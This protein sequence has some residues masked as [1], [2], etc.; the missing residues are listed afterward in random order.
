MNALFSVDA[1]ERSENI[2]AIEVERSTLVSARVIEFEG[3]QRLDFEEV[4]DNIEAQLRADEA[5]RLAREFGDGLLAKL[6]AGEALDDEWST[7][8]RVQRA[9]PT[10]PPAAMQAVFGAPAA[11]LPAH[12]GVALPDGGYA[13]YRVETVNRAQLDDDDSRLQAMVGQ[14]EQLMAEKDFNAYL[15]SLRARYPVEI[16]AA[17]L[18]TEER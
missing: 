3:A 10:L 7:I 18:R 6:S 1:R 9:S 2:E 4:R 5:G 15:G 13:L 11:Q 17:A 8:Q 16:R 12:V 14:Y